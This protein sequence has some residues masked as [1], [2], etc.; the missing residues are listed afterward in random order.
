MNIHLAAPVSRVWEHLTDPGKISA[1]L[2]ESDLVLEL[3]AGFT[4]TAEPAG[5]WDG[6][7]HC[8]IRDIVEFKVLSYTWNANDIGAET[9]V[10]F[11]LAEEEG[12]TRLKLT[13]TQFNSALPGAKGRHAA[14][15]TNC[16]KSLERTLCGPETG[17]DWS[18]MQIS[19]F[20]EA[21]PADIFAMWS[22]AAGMQSFWPDEI[23]CARPDGEERSPGETY[24]IGDRIHMTFPTHGSTGLEIINIETDKF[25]TF[26][27]GEGYGWVNV[28]LSKEGERTRIVVRQFGSS[29]EG[30]SPWEIHAHA[31]GWWIFNLVNLKSVLLHGRDLR[32]RETDAEN[33]LGATYLPGGKSA[34]VPHD[35]TAFDIFL[36][37]NALPHV[38]LDRWRSAGG[39]ESFFIAKADFTD[40]TGRPREMNEP[41]R[42]GDTYVW[43]TIHDFEMKG[44]MTEASDTRIAFTFGSRFNCEVTATPSHGGTLLHLQQNGM[45]D[46]PED[47][48]HGSLN[49]RSCWIYFLMTLKSQLEYG[50]DLRDHVAETADAIAVGFNQTR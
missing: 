18:E 31:R 25:I 15:W 4:F 21:Q 20:V 6:K 32:V 39:F 41:V 50:I 46:D 30:E 12:G 16:L 44:M 2:M 36:Q 40:E 29:T 19:L 22:T 10:T 13:H 23:R 27:F 11:E 42:K 26:S 8:E 35:W 37:I 3:G 33:G 48:V 14:G 47:R 9:L 7:I 28:L 5:T 34:P 45:R 17:Y 24:Q 1:W 49:C 43:R 38:V